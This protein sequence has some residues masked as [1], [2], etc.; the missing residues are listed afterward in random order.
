MVTKL[1]AALIEKLSLHIDLSKSRLETLALLITGMIGARTV[2]L[3]HVASE[4][5]S[6]V[7]PTSTYRRLQR[8]FQHVAPDGSVA[9]FVVVFRLAG[10]VGISAASTPPLAE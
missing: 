2:N 9:N 4:R 8:F 3:S 7:K 5:G 1:S 10:V 6:P